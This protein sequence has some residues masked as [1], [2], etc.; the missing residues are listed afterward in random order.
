LSLL[1]ATSPLR[2]EEWTARIA[3]RGSGREKPTIRGDSV[4]P[5]AQHNNIGLVV[6][7]CYASHVKHGSEEK[8]DNRLS[9][10]KVAQRAHP[11]S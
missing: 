1:N 5:S 2:G 4:E 9:V 11:A 10:Q 3:A 7:H 6:S 8:S